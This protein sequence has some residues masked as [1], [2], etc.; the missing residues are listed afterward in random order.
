MNCTHIK[1]TLF[2][3]FFC[4]TQLPQAVGIAYSLK[5]DKKE[6]CV[7]A[8]FGDGTTS[9]VYKDSNNEIFFKKCQK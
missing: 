8:Y 7:V 5:M 2:F 3:N 4:R 6:A 9:E 1:Y